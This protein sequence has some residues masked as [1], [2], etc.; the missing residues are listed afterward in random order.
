VLVADWPPEASPWMALGIGSGEAPQSLS[1][2]PML[3]RPPA[4]R[5]CCWA[6]WSAGWPI[7]AAAV[8]GSAICALA[9]AALLALP[10]GYAQTLTPSCYGLEVVAL[11]RLVIK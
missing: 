5:I 4:I 10:F 6:S 7:A 11:R 8:P 2:P 3:N 9:A 1:D